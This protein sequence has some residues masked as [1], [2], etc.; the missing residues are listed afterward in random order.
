MHAYEYAFLAAWG[1]TVAVETA[2]LL[3]LNLWRKSAKTADVLFAGVLCSSL[4]I[5]YLWFV[6]PIFLHPRWVYVGVS[7]SLIIVIEALLLYRLLRL[8]GRDAFLASLLANGAS[9]AAGYVRYM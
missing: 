9:I 1:I 8:S 4:T 5:P 7:E 3:L 6:M 2:V